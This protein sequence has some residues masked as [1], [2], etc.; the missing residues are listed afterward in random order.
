M[1]IFNSCVSLPEGKQIILEIIFHWTPWLF[2]LNHCKT[3]PAV[4]AVTS[5]ATGTS[6]AQSSCSAN[7]GQIEISSMVFAIRKIAVGVYV[8]PRSTNFRDVYLV[9]K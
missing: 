6:F 7:S 8:G 2:Q 9:C 3:V 5:S 4:I 1:V